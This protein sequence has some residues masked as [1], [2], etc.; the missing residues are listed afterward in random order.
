MK[1][2][3]KAQNGV[4]F[5]LYLARAGR[6]NVATAA[7]N[8]GLSSAFL[9]QIART[10]RIK[11]VV[12]AVRGPGG[13]FE[14]V[15]NPTMDQVIKAMG[16]DGFLSKAESQGYSRGAPEHRAFANFI[17]GTSMIVSKSLS[18]P[19]RDIM[20]SLSQQEKALLETASPNDRAV[21]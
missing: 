2:T 3:K 9:D 8:L 14:L 13:G 18:L 15:G 11:G 10:L 16:A 4:L 6:A 5:C 17:G 1:L 19:I 20:F 21:V 12:T 7:D